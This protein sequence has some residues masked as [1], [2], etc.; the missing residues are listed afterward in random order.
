MKTIMEKASEKFE[1]CMRP[2]K[3]WVLYYIHNGLFGPVLHPWVEVKSSSIMNNQKD[4][5]MGLFAMR[6]FEPAEEI[7]I[8][9][10]LYQRA[11]EKDQSKFLLEYKKGHID[12]PKKG[13]E[14]YSYLCVRY[15]YDERPKLASY[16][17]RFKSE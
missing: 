11:S 7:G 3:T 14:R 13:S 5:N 8:Y 10:G 4:F 17:W 1:W 16:W 15:A 9:L 12:I 2:D 6:S